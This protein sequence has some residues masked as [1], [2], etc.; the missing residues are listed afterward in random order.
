MAQ[1]G[2]ELPLKPRQTLSL[3]SSYF[4]FPSSIGYMPAPDIFP[5][6]SS[7]SWLVVM[8]GLAKITS[9]THLPFGIFVIH[10]PWHWLSTCELASIMM[11]LAWKTA[12]GQQVRQSVAALWYV[13]AW[14]GCSVLPSMISTLSFVSLLL[15]Q[16]LSWEK[17]FLPSVAF[18]APGP[19]PPF[20]FCQASQN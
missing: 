2:L 20:F 12:L 5:F 14:Q 3:E 19:F 17:L 4:S 15:K 6:I 10:L 18:L 16:V 13:S 7:T 9:F 1:A 11:T 8:A